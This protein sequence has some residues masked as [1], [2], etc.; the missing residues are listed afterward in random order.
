[1]AEIGYVTPVPLTTKYHVTDYKNR[2][3]AKTSR[4]L[5]AYRTWNC[6]ARC[7]TGNF[8]SLFQVLILWLYTFSLF[9]VDAQNERRVRKFGTAVPSGATVTIVCNLPKNKEVIQR[10]WQRKKDSKDL[11]LND[12][13]LRYSDVDG[14]P[15]RSKT[16]FVKTEENK[17]SLQIR[18]VRP[19]EA[20][21]YRCSTTMSD[22]I[23]Q[24]QLIG[25]V[26]VIERPQCS[27]KKLPELQ[28]GSPFPMNCS[29]KY[30]GARAPI[31]QWMVG[32]HIRDQTSREDQGQRAT[33]ILDYEPN[34]KDFGAIPKCEVHHPKWNSSYPVGS[35]QYRPITVSFAPKLSC[36]KN[37]VAV[38]KADEY[39]VWCNYTSHPVMEPQSFKWKNTDGQDLNHTMHKEVVRKIRQGFQAILEVKSEVFE[40]FD[41][42]GE[43]LPFSEA[44]KV[45]YQIVV[46]D[47]AGKL[48]FEEKVSLTLDLQEPANNTSSSSFLG[49]IQDWRVLIGVLAAF[50]AL[51]IVVILIIIILKKG[52][53]KSEKHSLNG[54]SSGTEVTGDHIGINNDIAVGGAFDVAHLDGGGHV[55]LDGSGVNGSNGVH[56]FY[57]SGKNKGSLRF[58]RY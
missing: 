21:E 29:V 43:V 20:G 47:K 45:I 50:S 58:D 26:T 17:Y 51:V 10:R 38:K 18:N 5:N 25:I 42:N 33:A 22:G 28:E 53:C 23:I 49:I 30:Y 36:T 15:E 2:Q 13:W 39:R 41:E 34:Y 7:L 24:D 4:V 11:F 40:K 27:P 9:E 6:L 14:W 44:Q 48:E 54:T 35:C 1:M 52:F 57:H 56:E 55:G 32:T 3:R 46:H 19:E 37:R 8:S 12:I 16:Y 31:L